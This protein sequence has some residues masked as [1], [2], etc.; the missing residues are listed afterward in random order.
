MPV[1]KPGSGPIGFRLLPRNARRII[2]DAIQHSPEGA[3]CPSSSVHTAQLGYVCLTDH[4]RHS[5]DAQ[6]A[7]VLSLPL[8]HPVSKTGRMDL[9]Q[10]CDAPRQVARSRR[11][12]R[13]VIAPKRW[14]RTWT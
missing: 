3:L 9:S 6:V 8:R 2:Q 7:D 10:K 12:N 13:K 11:T 1:T 5:C 14:P 4:F